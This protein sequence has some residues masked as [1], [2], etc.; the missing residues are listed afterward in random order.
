M[1]RRKHPAAVIPPHIHTPEHKH[2]A[3]AIFAQNFSFSFNYTTIPDKIQ[4]NASKKKEAKKKTRFIDRSL[5]SY[6]I[7]REN[8]RTEIF[9]PKKSSARKN[10]R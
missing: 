5:L 2:K 3:E 7:T 6:T 10:L 8:E 4:Y 9:D 1:R